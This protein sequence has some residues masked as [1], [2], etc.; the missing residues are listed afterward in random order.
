MSPITF[1]LLFRW[2]HIRRANI[3]WSRGH[4]WLCTGPWQDG[5]TKS[6]ETPVSPP[7]KK[8][9]RPAPHLKHEEELATA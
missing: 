7:T 3:E 5:P 2:R 9:Y 6:L 4:D 1:Y 8:V